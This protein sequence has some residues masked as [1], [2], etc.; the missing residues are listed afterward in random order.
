MTQHLRVIQAAIEIVVSGTVMTTAIVTR[1]TNVPMWLT[2]LVICSCLV[3]ATIYTPLDWL[4][5]LVR[6]VRE[7]VR[8]K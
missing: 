2:T 5:Q 6:A 8:S 3:A 7:R 1:P 4:G